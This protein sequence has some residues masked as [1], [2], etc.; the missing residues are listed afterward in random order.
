[1]GGSVE[2]LEL[3]YEGKWLKS[4]S[5]E[6]DTPLKMSSVDRKSISLRTHTMFSRIQQIMVPKLWIIT[7]I[8]LD[9][10]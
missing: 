7:H 6:W 4:T 2:Q 8:F 10:S 1:M 9:I 3:S 5:T